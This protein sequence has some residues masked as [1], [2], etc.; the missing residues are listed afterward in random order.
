MAGKSDVMAGSA[1]VRIWLKDDLSKSIS[2]SLKS[3]GES[4]KTFGSNAKQVGGAMMGAGAALAA[5]LAGALVVG[6]KYEDVMLDIAASTGISSDELAQLNEAALAAKVG[7]TAAAQSFLELLKAGMSVED[8]L[9]GAGDAAI[10]FARVG[11]MEAGEA[12]VVMADAMKVFGVAADMAANTISAAADASSTD[13]QGMSQAFAQSSAVAALANQ[14][15]EDTAAA[16]AVLANAGVKGSD[17]GTSLKTMLLKLMA[18][19]EQATGALS[20][21]GLSVDSFRGADGKLLPMVEILGRLQSATAGMDATA[22]DAAFTKIFGTDAIRAAAILSTAGAEGFS[23]MRDGMASALP[24]SEKFETVMSGLSGMKANVMATLERLA[25]VVANGLKPALETVVP[26]V[27]QAV[28]FVSVLAQ[29]NTWLIPTLAAVAAGLTAAGGALVALGFV[30]GPLGTSLV[31]LSGVVSAFGAVAGVLFGPA[32]ILLAG[33]AAITAAW[34]TFTESGQTAMGSLSK[35][36]DVFG[37]TF[38]GVKAAIMDGDFGGAIDIL[39][40]GVSAAWHTGLAGLLEQ[41]GGFAKG[42]LEVFVGIASAVSRLWVDMQTGIA[43]KIVDWASQE[44]GTGD[45]IRKLLG[46]DPRKSK[47]KERMTQQQRA[48]LS[49]Q[50]RVW[51]E[52]KTRVGAS[53]TVEGGVLAGTTAAQLDEWISGALAKMQMDNA[54]LTAGQLGVAGPEEAKAALEAE[55]AARQAAIDESL[56]GLLSGF[57]RWTNA[58][59]QRAADARARL[60]G[61]ITGREAAAEEAAMQAAADEWFAQRDAEDAAEAAVAATTPGPGATPAAATPIGGVSNLA[62][63]NA[64]ALQAAGVMGVRDPAERTA[65]GIEKLAEK[66][67]E[68]KRLAAEGNTTFAKLNEAFDRY[69]TALSYA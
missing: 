63:Y 19:T 52:A 18:P 7:P 61:A 40:A 1:F 37:E 28:D 8:V 54:G 6:A 66:L 43:K 59:E 12:A 42:V 26:Y 68:Q 69:I 5:P 32:G 36:L 27:Q 38:D 49:E 15:I 9:G 21:M 45:V 64:S 57:D 25:I 51:E 44:G 33:L 2:R 47:A 60:G 65:T 30:A 58:A 22:R 62:S 10:A 46:V 48:G 17:A 34:L 41:T 20:G 35:L 29:R 16:L 14:S 3:A 67:E 11:Q 50:V 53:G 56:G 23:A 4:L 39:M 31:M 13:I 55:N 24:V